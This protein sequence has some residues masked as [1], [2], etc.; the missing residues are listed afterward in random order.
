MSTLLT[1]DDLCERWR[2][3]PATLPRYRSQG[4]IAIRI[5]GGMKYRLEDVEAFEEKKATRKKKRRKP[6]LVQEPE[7]DLLT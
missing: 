4:L 3:S 1:D 5:G 7:M 2:C 6:V